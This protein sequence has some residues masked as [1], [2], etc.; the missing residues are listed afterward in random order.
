MDVE[1]VTRVDRILVFG[2][3]AN[4]ASRCLFSITTRVTQIKIGLEWNGLEWIEFK[5][6]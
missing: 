4:Y 5:R 6:N 3:N 2:F 1:L